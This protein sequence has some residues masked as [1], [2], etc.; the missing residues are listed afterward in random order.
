MLI[1]LVR[2][3]GYTTPLINNIYIY[4]ICTLKLR[5]C[6]LAEELESG[7]ASDNWIFKICLN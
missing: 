5:V 7:W 6:R 1:V 2:S 3:G 4:F